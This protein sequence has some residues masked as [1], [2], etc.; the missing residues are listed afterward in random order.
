VGR[1]GSGYMSTFGQLDRAIEC[2]L[3]SLGSEH[4]HRSVEH[5]TVRVN[6]FEKTMGV[7]DYH[8]LCFSRANDVNQRNN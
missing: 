2:I 3:Y 8:Y 4:Q 1:I 7:R 5:D 6:V